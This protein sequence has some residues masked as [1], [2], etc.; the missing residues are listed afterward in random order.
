MEQDGPIYG[1][2]ASE[3]ESYFLYQYPDDVD[4]SNEGTSLM[5]H[6]EQGVAEECHPQPAGEMAV[7]R[8]SKKKMQ[9]RLAQ[10]TYRTYN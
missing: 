1:S 7:D 6:P 3:L 5:A 10:R 9:N 4:M 8:I 2:T